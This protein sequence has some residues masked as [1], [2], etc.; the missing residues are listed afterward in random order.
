MQQSFHFRYIGIK[1]NSKHL[2]EES[3]ALHFYIQLLLINFI[4]LQRIF[5]LGI[6]NNY[7]YTKMKPDFDNQYNKSQK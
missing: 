4:F 7:G 2:L 5:N 6:T 3:P 1:E